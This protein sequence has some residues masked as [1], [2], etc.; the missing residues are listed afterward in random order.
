M[1]GDSASREDNWG[2][3]YYTFITIIKLIGNINANKNYNCAFGV[4]YD[5]YLKSLGRVIRRIFQASINCCS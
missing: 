5:S 1:G 3:T 4:L 2:A